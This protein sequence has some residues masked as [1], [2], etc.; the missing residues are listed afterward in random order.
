MI[1]QKGQSLVEAVIALGVVTIIVSAMAI[2]VVSA[3]SSSDY[4]KYENQATHSAQQGIEILRQ[5]SQSDWAGFIK[6]LDQGGLYQ[7]GHCLADP[8]PDTNKFT[9]EQLANCDL[10]TSMPNVKP[11]FIRQFS[12]TKD[13][14]TACGGDSYYG[15][16]A[17][18]WN[19]G[20]C[21]NNDLYCHKV[22][23]DTCL[24]NINAVPTL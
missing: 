6:P 3:V 13:I 7:G 18:Y 1:N 24:G 10:Q 8:D 2:A 15:Q 17:V 22:Q 5:E 21:Q 9:P 12:V 14:N 19:D 11:N 16:V 20:K 4:S 23:L